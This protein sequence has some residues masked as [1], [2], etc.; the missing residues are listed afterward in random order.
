MVVGG[1][2]EVGR[3]ID[4]QI[5]TLIYLCKCL[6]ENGRCFRH[7]VTVV[8]RSDGFKVRDETGIETESKS[9]PF[10]LC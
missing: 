7:L 9:R 6:H 10:A 1:R 8:P 5:D 2:R 4:T 3:R